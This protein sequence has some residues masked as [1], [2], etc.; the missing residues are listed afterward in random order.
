M[1]VVGQVTRF[2]EVLDKLAAE[3][4]SLD[5]YEHELRALARRWVEELAAGDGKAAGGLSIELVTGLCDALE[6]ERKQ[7][8]RLCELLVWEL[9]GV[10]DEL[11]A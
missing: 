10:P 4:A 3:R 11:A 6:R 9:R 1:A 2:D 8:A 7:S 5:F